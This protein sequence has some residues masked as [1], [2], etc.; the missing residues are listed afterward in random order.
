MKTGGVIAYPAEGC[1]G[2]GCDPLNRRAVLRI[3]KLKHRSVN[4]GLILVA[5]S[6]SQL[7]PWLHPDNAGLLKQPLR[8]WPGPFTWVL[9]ASH[10]APSW[11]TGAHSTIA[12]RISAKPEIVRLCRAFKGAIVST[13]ANPH[14]RPPAT[15]RAQVTRYFGRHIDM[16]VN[17]FPGPL[18]QPTEIR[19]TR[20]GEVLRWQSTSIDNSRDPSCP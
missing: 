2:L 16:L 19:D 5:M 13:S 1:F 7:R 11:I 12:V 9:P 20:T 14:G 6:F 10:R 18:K 3:L 17:G 15:S 8:S 4:Q